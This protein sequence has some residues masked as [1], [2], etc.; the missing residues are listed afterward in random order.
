MNEELDTW[1][2][3]A[4]VLLSDLF[5]SPKFENQDTWMAY[6][7]HT[8]TVLS[9]DHLPASN[10]IDQAKLLYCVFWAQRENGDYAVA[11]MMAWKSLD[12]REKVLGKKHTH[13][14]HSLINLGIVFSKQGRSKEAEQINRQAI[15]GLEEMLGKQHLDTLMTINNLGLG[16]GDQGKY[17]EAEKMHLRAMSA[18]PS[19]SARDSITSSICL[20]SPAG[21]RHEVGAGF[22]S[23][24]KESSVLRGL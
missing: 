2:E 12:L 9:L 22:G 24:K 18:Q 19:T 21:S 14:L 20:T 11:E 8:H 7:P 16:L 10:S 17:E 23:G 1:A 4:L 15:D 5:P 6:L 13:T 3:K